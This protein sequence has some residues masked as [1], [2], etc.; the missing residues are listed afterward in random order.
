MQW[1]R[2]DF[3]AI[4]HEVSL[5]F[6]QSKLTDGW[7]ERYNLKA[8]NSASS[9]NSPMRR[10]TWIPIQDVDSSGLWKGAW[11]APLRGSILQGACLLF[12]FLLALCSWAIRSVMGLPLAQFPG[13]SGCSMPWFV[14]WR[15]PLVSYCLVLAQ[16]LPATAGLTLLSA[17]KAAIKIHKAG[18]CFCLSQWSQWCCLVYSGLETESVSQRCCRLTRIILNGRHSQRLVRRYH[19][20]DYKNI[21]FHSW[22]TNTRGN[23]C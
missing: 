11:S 8:I 9:P 21:I 19:C 17:C 2:L 13:A 6:C 4:F 7:E 12:H 3:V 15:E 18:V 22:F 23:G 10:S 14:A 20:W 16:F 1:T 5:S